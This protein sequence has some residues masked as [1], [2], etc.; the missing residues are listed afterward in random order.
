[1]RAVESDLKIVNIRLLSYRLEAL[2]PDDPSEQSPNPVQAWPQIDFQIARNNENGVYRILMD[3]EGSPEREGYAY[4]VR[5]AGFFSL[6]DEANDERRDRLILYSALPMM[7]STVRG[8]VSDMT[9]HSV[10]GRYFLPSVDLA[11]LLSDWKGD[12]D[13]TELRS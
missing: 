2:L 3:V 8:L 5:L 9:A 10:Y 12:V 4:S 7:I 13:E 1:M 11:A 6:P